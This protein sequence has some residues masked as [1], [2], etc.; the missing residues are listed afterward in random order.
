MA[1]K[2]QKIVI[3][4]LLN[5]AV[6]VTKK[7]YFS[8]SDPKTVFFENFGP[9]PKKVPNSARTKIENPRTFRAAD[10]RGCRV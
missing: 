3:K 9:P 7:T 6:P 2:I 1:E 4:K 8:L 10:P 5:S